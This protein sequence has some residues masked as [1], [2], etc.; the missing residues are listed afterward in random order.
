M[1]KMRGSW[2]GSIILEKGL[3]VIIDQHYETDDSRLTQLPTKLL[4]NSP[5]VC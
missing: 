5:N 2:F 3:S 4:E 1:Y